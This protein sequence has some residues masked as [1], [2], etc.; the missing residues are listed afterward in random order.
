MA[1]LQYTVI[2]TFTN[3][4]RNHIFSQKL[5]AAEKQSPCCSSEVDP[6]VIPQLSHMESAL[7]VK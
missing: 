7:Y 2:C 1:Q 6:W 3:D 4:F 5:E